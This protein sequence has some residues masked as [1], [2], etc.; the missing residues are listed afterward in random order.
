MISVLHI[1]RVPIQQDLEVGMGAEIM[2]Q[3]ATR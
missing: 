1:I 2:C 3:D